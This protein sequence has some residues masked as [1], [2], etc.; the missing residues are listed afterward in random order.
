MW[1]L[2]KYI[3]TSAWKTFQIILSE[4]DSLT[5]SLYYLVNPF[6]KWKNHYVPSN[7]F[8]L[9]LAF[10]KGRIWICPLC[11]KTSTMWWIG[12][13][14]LSLLNNLNA[15]SNTYEIFL[16]AWGGLLTWWWYKKRVGKEKRGLFQRSLAC[17]TENNWNLS[18]SVFDCLCKFL[19]FFH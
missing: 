18:F 2:S 11:R 5:R 14:N 12:N 7:V 10:K 13:S 17:F 9:R 6:C 3:D 19:L 4:W 16:G 1:S 8:V 15:I